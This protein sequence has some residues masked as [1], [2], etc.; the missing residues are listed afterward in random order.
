MF[1]QFRNLL[2][3]GSP[4]TY[5]FEP[6]PFVAMFFSI[7]FKVCT[8]DSSRFRT[9]CSRFFLLELS[10]EGEEIQQARRNPTI[11]IQDGCLCWACHCGAHHAKDPVKLSKSAQMRTIQVDVKQV[12]RF[13]LQQTFLWNITNL[14]LA[15]NMD[16]IVLCHPNCVSSCFVFLF[17]LVNFIWMNVVFD[18]K[19]VFDEIGFWWNV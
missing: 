15:Q 17:N 13:D 11:P 14:R 1:L 16:Y 6:I 18:E 4:A 19:M 9:R 2:P 5:R 8:Q 7:H 3:Y 10:L 12:G